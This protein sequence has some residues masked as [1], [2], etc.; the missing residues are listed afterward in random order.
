MFLQKLIYVLLFILPISCSIKQ[1][2]NEKIEP[3]E[4]AGLDFVK[5]PPGQ[6]KMNHLYRL[7]E[8]VSAPVLEITC[9]FFISVHEISQGEYSNIMG[10]NSITK[11]AKR[12]PDLPM[13]GMLRKEIDV[14]CQKLEEKAKEEG[15]DVQFRLPTLWELYY[16]ACGKEHTMP[17]VEDIKKRELIGLPDAT[18]R[19]IFR[20]VN[21]GKVN[22]FGTRDIM[23]NIEELCSNPPVTEITQEEVKWDP[24]QNPATLPIGFKKRENIP[25]S[26][27]ERLTIRNTTSP[28]IAAEYF[29]HSHNDAISTHRW[30]WEGFRLIAL[31][32]DKRK[33]ISPN[34]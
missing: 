19:H 22:S 30:V 24:F 12:N 20:S 14:F 6:V 15:W 4:I 33:K 21:A 8:G 11:V 34:N 29:G 13:T 10:G 31:E 18:K 26:S 3:V 28:T 23:G 27:V 7:G 16:V 32:V 9:P 5:I 17:S 25:D 1:D 2:F